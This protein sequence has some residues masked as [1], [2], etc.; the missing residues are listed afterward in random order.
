M[1]RQSLITLLLVLGSNISWASPV[2][3]IQKLISQNR[4]QEAL[5]KIETLLT[6]DPGDVE[7]N[8]LHAATLSELDQVEKAIKIYET[9]IS[10]HPTL[11][12]PR[13]NL[14]VLYAK[15]QSF[16]KAEGALQSALN[17]HPSY[18]TAHENL[19]DIYKAL[20]SVAYNKAFN[21]N[22]PA[23]PITPNL[24]LVTELLSLPKTE[25]ATAPS[26]EQLSSAEIMPLAQKPEMTPTITKTAEEVDI[27]RVESS[28]IAW[29]EAWSKQDTD[30]YLG[31]Y[32]ADFKPQAPSS[33]AAWKQQ[34]RDRLKSPKFIK[35]GISNLQTTILSPT[36]VG[37]KFKQNYKS[38][39]FSEKSGKLLLLK[40]E[41]DQWRIALETEAG[42]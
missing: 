20:A 25:P 42:K 21:D 23:S 17:T 19:S 4:F 39:R 9:I 26:I 24:R 10:E 11:P 5:P 33:L 15:Q 40:L 36:A 27:T 18:A 14:A 29:G 7:L 22:K 16:E 30:S 1:L 34:R 41:Q 31:F 3:D 28:V 38:D 6:A 8:F 35:I 12:E 32:S 2:D 13:N 37:V